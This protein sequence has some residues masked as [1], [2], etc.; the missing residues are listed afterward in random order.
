MRRIACIILA[1]IFIFYARE[2]FAYKVKFVKDADAQSKN[3][4]VEVPE[5]REKL[6]EA[7]YEEIPLISAFPA[8]IEMAK[9]M[10]STKLKQAGRA[11]PTDALKSKPKFR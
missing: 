9:A 2:T 8:A 3:T 1:L 7:G 11:Y 4:I 6:D 10:V 5:I